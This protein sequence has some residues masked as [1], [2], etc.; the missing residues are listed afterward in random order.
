MSHTVFDATPDTQAIPVL[1]TDVE[2]ADPTQNCGIRKYTLTSIDNPTVDLTPFLSI[3]T[4]PS[5]QIKL[6]SN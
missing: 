3:V 5:L 1:S 2:T 6:L 4:A